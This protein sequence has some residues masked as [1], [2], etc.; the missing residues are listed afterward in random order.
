M[1]ALHKIVFCGALLSFCAAAIAQRASPE[2]DAVA[3]TA[4]RNPVD[5]PYRRMVAGMERFEKRR[6]LAPG[7][8]LRFKLLPRN[9]DTRMENL[10]LEIASTSFATAVVIASDHTFTLA[11]DAGALKENASVVPNR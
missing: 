9:R 3:V 1:T 5:K 7:A 4:L 10:Q 11:R 8:A 2:I 6:H